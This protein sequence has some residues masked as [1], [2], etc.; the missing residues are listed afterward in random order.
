MAELIMQDKLRQIRVLEEVHLEMKQ[1]TEDSEIALAGMEEENSNLRTTIQQLQAMFPK[2]IEQG[3]KQSEKVKES[4]RRN[5]EV[6]KAEKEALHSKLAKKEDFNNSFET[7]EEKYN[8]A[9]QEFQ[10]E[11][12]KHEHENARMILLVKK[13]E[14]GL[15]IRG[16]ADVES[17]VGGGGLKRCRQVRVCVDQ[18]SMSD[19]VQKVEMRDEIRTED[20]QSSDYHYDRNKEPETGPTEANHRK[21]LTREE[22]MEISRRRKDIEEEK[23]ELEREM[24]HDNE[25]Q[26]DELRDDTTEDDRDDEVLTNDTNKPR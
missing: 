23:E 9:Q 20:R 12:G 18:S 10:K 11:K 4:M 19:I 17:E 6:L 25:L 22:N 26:D 8:D 16:R 13:E 2:V 14:V 3:K 5:E 1:Q 15:G 21:K 24:I 7:L